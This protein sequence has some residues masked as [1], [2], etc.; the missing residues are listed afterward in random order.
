MPHL[1]L[2]GVVACF[3][4]PQCNGWASARDPG[5][6]DHRESDTRPCAVALE[7]VW[8]HAGLR[9]EFAEQLFLSATDAS[10]V[11]RLGSEEHRRPPRL[12]ASRSRSPG[13]RR[14]QS[15]PRRSPLSWTPSTTT[16]RR[17]ARRY[18]MLDDV[19][20]SASLFQG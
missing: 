2:F 10:A 16:A 18:L 15:V 7:R 14:V 11:I 8:R 12:H 3:S 1:P 6:R 13:L 20:G 5:H 19:R 17:L 9:E 4:P